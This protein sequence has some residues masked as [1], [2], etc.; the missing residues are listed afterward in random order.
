M[1]VHRCRFVEYQPASINALDFT[2]FTVKINK[3]KAISFEIMPCNL[4][5]N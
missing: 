4:K 1:E 2:P 3:S 5:S